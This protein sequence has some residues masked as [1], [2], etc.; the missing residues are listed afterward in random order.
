LRSA[1][2]ARPSRPAPITASR[3]GSSGFGL[4]PNP[5]FDEAAPRLGDPARYYADPSYY[6][7]KDLV[8]PYRV[9]MSCGF[10]HCRGRTRSI[11]RRTPEHPK[12]ENLSSTVGAQYFWIDR[13]FNWAA[14]PTSFVF[15]LIHTARPGT[16]DTSLV[17][18][19]N[20]NNPRTIN[21]VYNL[22][23]RL[24]A[25]KR[26]GKETLAGG[27]LDNRQFNDFVKE[28][29]LTQ[30]FAPPGPVDPDVLKDWLRSPSCALG[31][32]NRVY[33]NIVCSRGVAAALHPLV[34]GKPI[35]PDQIK[36]MRKNSAYL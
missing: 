8:R 12:W 14:D 16:L 2:A 30:L 32:L 24:E 9:G 23:P 19:D 11:R 17:S 36:V 35:S 27:N 3:R 22:G 7:R 15:Q 29:P 10:C 21:A 1:R 34:G 5:D 18:T 20:V 13:I 31:A 6:L 4:F 26:W 33:V 28:G 25:A